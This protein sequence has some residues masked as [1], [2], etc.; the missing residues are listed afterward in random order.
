MHSN[1]DSIKYVVKFGTEDSQD[2]RLTAP[3]RGQFS[4]DQFTDWSFNE[5]YKLQI[6]PWKETDPNVG[7]TTRMYK[8]GL[9]KD[10][11]IPP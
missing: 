7:P 2:G 11:I 5:L 4:Y 9:I 6:K 8:W 10:Q 3:V 1:R